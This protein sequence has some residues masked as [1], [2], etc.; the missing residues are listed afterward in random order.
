M[1]INIFVYTCICLR[2]LI[3]L[4]LFVIILIAKVNGLQSQVLTVL[5][6]FSKNRLTEGL[7]NRMPQAGSRP[8]TDK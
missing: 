3:Y 8:A 6:R 2:I 7:T 5:F 1:L 4:L